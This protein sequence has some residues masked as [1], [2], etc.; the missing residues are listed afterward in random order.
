[1][2]RRVT[3]AVLTPAY[4][5]KDTL[6]KLYDS[7]K[8]QTCPDFFWLIVDD[9]SGDGT[10]GLVRGWMEE[11]QVEI[12]FIR[13]EN[14]GKH[15]ALNEGIG[16]VKQ[17]LVFIVDSDDYL[18]ED[19]VETVLAYAEKYEAE[20]ETKKLCGFCFLRHDSEGKVNT[21]YFPKDEYID[22]Y[23][24]TRINGNIGGDKAE[25]FYTEAL[26]QFP[27]KEYP[28][29]KFMPEDAVWIAMSQKYDMVHINKGIYICDYLEGGLTRTGRAMKIH[30]PKG[31]MLRSKLFLNDGRVCLKVKV[32]MALLYGV[33]SG[34]AGIRFREAAA[35]LGGKC[36]WG[37]ALFYLCYLPS[38][39]IRRRWKK[40]LGLEE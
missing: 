13:K 6:E 38:V 5:R 9:G 39:M 32:K 22:N 12:G 4:N 10:E 26:R 36:V 20:R 27:F 30:S 34:F 24:E 35:A 8:A 33:Y 1:M 40:Q 31:M 25:V 2:K 23:V 11:G 7:L 29:E 18:T 28:G 21:A 3:L 19:A 14:G 15:T 37:Y 17:D 16:K